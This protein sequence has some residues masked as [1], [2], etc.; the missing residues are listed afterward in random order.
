MTGKMLIPTMCEA[1]YHAS[2]KI[3]EIYNGSYS[4]DYKE[5]SSPVTTADL[6]SEGIIL[7]L[8]KNGFPAAS[9]LSEESAER[10][11]EER[12]TNGNG[13][14]I[15]DPLDGTVEF[16][17][18]TG[19][20]SVSIGFSRDHRMEA[21]V[22]AIPEKKILY[23]AASGEGAYRL[24]FDGYT[25]GFSF[26]D[27]ERLHV[28]DR[29]GGLVLTVS[30][31]Y[32]TPETDALIE[33]NRDRIGEVLTV[34]S[35]LKGCLIAEGTADVHYRFGAKTKEW[36]TSAMQ[37][38]VTEA[39]GIFTDL[40]GREIESNRADYVNRNGFIIL[41]RRESALSL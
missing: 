30:R 36:D 29:T 23:Y 34:G 9:V 32:N 13:V 11:S 16:V 33:R 1:A 38:I 3:S 2:L 35:C 37:C 40:D 26:G 31:S 27:G 10:E 12:L 18:R 6:A 7:P 14:F 41:N 22:I 25:H 5:D 28:S 4:V 8:L 19:E 39:G 24:T 21:G 20:F 17:A 15:V